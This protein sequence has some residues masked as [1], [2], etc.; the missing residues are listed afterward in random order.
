MRFFLGHVRDVNHLIEAT[1]D[2]D[3]VVHAAALKQVPAAEYNPTETIRTNIYGAKNL[4]R[5]SIENNVKSGVA[6]S[7][8]KAAN[9]V[10]LY[11]ATKLASDKLFIAANSIAGKRETRFSVIRY[12]NVMGSRGSVIPFFRKLIDE[13]SRVLPVT[14]KEM[15]RF[16]ITPQQGVMF[17]ERAFLRMKGGGYLS[18]RFHR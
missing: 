3:H 14:D 5:A 1:R 6:L 13:G 15:T 8:D 12:G 11:G 18:Q 17:V 4:V 16:S 9:P 10:N 7:T 2:V